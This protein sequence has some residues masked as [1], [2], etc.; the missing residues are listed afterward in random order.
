MESRRREPVSEPESSHDLPRFLSACVGP[1]GGRLLPVCCPDSPA[2]SSRVCFLTSGFAV[3]AYPLLLPG[4]R[5]SSPLRWTSRFSASRWRSLAAVAEGDTLTWAARFVVVRESEI[6]GSYRKDLSTVTFSLTR[7]RY[8]ILAP[9]PTPCL[10]QGTRATA[11][12]VWTF[13]RCDRPTARA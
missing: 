8:A 7:A 1:H 11:R 5:C 9:P 12:D 3:V 10:S 2:T 13:V 6:Y 4:R